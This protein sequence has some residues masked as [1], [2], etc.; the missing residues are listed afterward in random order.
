M[1]SLSQEKPKMTVHHT[2]EDNYQDT[3]SQKSMSKK[4][5]VI[6]PI[7]SHPQDAGN[8][9]RIYNLIINMQKLGHDVHFLYIEEHEKNTDLMRLAW[10]NS[11][12]SCSDYILPGHRKRSL[13]ERII[14][15]LRCSL[16]DYPKFLNAV[17]DYY[18]DSISKYLVYLHKKVKFDVVIVEYVFYSKALNYFGK[19]VLKIIDTHDIFKD[20]VELYR[21]NG[22][23]YKWYSTTAKEESKG[24]RRADW[25]IAIQEK[26]EEY[27]KKI[28]GNRVI[29]IGHTVSLRKPN[30][31]LSPRQK[32]L[33]VASINE[34]NLHA[35][36]CFIREVLPKVCS[37]LPEVQLMIAGKICEVVE[38]ADGCIKLGYIDNINE[39]YDMADVVIN[40]ILFGTGLK[41]KSIEAL[42]QSKV[43]VTTP[44]GAKGLEEGSNTAFLVAKDS[45]EF[46]QHLIEVFTNATL[47]KSLSENAYKF[48]ENYNR[49]AIKPLE[50][51]LR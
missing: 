6:S 50:Q 17:D 43:L 38:E 34:T 36:N 46:A 3:L 32:I 4:V 31:M 18:H 30:Q 27:F 26:E 19:D 39:V 10:G 42:G 22:Q 1:S 20:R 9:N 25:I 11:F 15:K 5:L 8:R 28:V 2:T 21:K 13:L 37:K 48:A 14:R 45:E 40:P 12:Y 29:T 41:I 35:I 24:L 47:C 44:E 49:K 51:I 16:T 23:T 33:Y 7:P